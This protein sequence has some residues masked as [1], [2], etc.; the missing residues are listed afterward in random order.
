MSMI[1]SIAIIIIIIISISIII[2]IIKYIYYTILKR[3][4]GIGDCTSLTFASIEHGF[5]L[6]LN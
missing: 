4:K 2:I 3:H 1:I 6:C 5:E